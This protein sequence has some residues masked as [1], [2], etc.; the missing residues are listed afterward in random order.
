[1]NSA[2]TEY[3]RTCRILTAILSLAV[4]YL[5]PSDITVLLAIVMFRI[6]LL[7]CYWS[8]LNARNT[9]LLEQ[10]GKL[11]L[12][13]NYANLNRFYGSS[14]S[15]EGTSKTSFIWWGC[16]CSKE[17]SASLYYWRYK[18]A[19]W[20]IFLLSATRKELGYK[21]NFTICKILPFHSE[22]FISSQGKRYIEL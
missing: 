4:S 11:E 18:N 1:V 5:S 15:R 17:S 20:I 16:W 22:K 6:L 3:L 13:N 10:V 19:A 7:I 12:N 9:F 8:Y 21:V 14:V 2:I